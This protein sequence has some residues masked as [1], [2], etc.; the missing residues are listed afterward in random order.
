MLKFYK[1]YLEEVIQLDKKVQ[2][3]INNKEYGR[4]KFLLKGLEILTSI[5]Q[6]KIEEVN[7]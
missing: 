1:N 2:Q 7:K 5:I 6:E 4:A 3:A